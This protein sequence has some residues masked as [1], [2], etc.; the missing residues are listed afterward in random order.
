MPPTRLTTRFS[1]ALTFAFT[2]H[3]QQERKGSR[4]P[5]MVHLLGTAAIVLHF[6]GD[7]D[8]AIAALL[9]D[10]AEDQG[11]LATLKTVR[12][13]FGNR[14]A[15]IV[16]RCSDTFE[17]PKPE[18]RRR[19]EAYLRKL[20]REPAS[21]LLVSAADKL[22]NA[23]AIVADL[24]AI[25]GGRQGEARN[26]VWLRFSGKKDG[27]LWYYDSLVAAY[28]RVARRAHIE[29]LAK[30]LRIVVGQMHELAE[31]PSIRS[32]PPSPTRPRRRPR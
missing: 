27:T 16:R 15:D 9:H 31:S 22:D 1:E 14:V 3:G 18:W 25:G 17:N 8:Q 21:A 10:S 7:E 11:G 32:C 30:E 5:Y 20:P 29:S 2:L 13:G 23:R 19:K 12:R 28:S 26:R 4:V 6:G 24:R